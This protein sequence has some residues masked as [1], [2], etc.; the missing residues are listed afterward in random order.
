MHGANG[1]ALAGLFS[2]IVL[3]GPICIIMYLVFKFLGSLGF[4]NKIKYNEEDLCKHTKHN[5]YYGFIELPHNKN[6]P[7][8]EDCWLDYKTDSNINYRTFFRTTSSGLKEVIIS[9]EDIRDYLDNKTHMSME[10]GYTKKRWESQLK[11]LWREHK[12]LM[13]DFHEDLEWIAEYNNLVLQRKLRR[14]DEY[15]YIY[16]DN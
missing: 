11:F 3:L 15:K 8:F 9:T 13:E 14:V 4:N 5:E 7:V 1:A 2:L 6:F 16:F 12:D 10:P